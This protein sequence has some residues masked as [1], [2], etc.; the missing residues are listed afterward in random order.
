MENKELRRMNRTELIEIIYAMQQ[1][2]KTLTAECESLRNQLADRNIRMETAGSI[3]EA[4]LKLNHIFESADEA[5]QQYLASI[6]DREE[7]IDQ[8]VKEKEENIDRI[9]KE[10]EEKADQILADAQKRAE[11]IIVAA[12]KIAEEL[13]ESAREIASN[14]ENLFKNHSEMISENVKKGRLE[15]G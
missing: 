12:E 7:N 15:N 14:V 1:N 2:E 6:K 10:K 5:A 13:T 3:A 9:V 8:I 4:A 11:E